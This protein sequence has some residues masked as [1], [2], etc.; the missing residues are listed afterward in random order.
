SLPLTPRQTPA[1][2][3]NWQRL[4]AARRQGTISG[5]VRSSE[6]GEPLSG[7]Q[8]VLDGT[9]R[10]TLSASNGSYSLADVPVGTYT[11]VARML[12][13]REVRQTDV[14]VVSGQ[15]INVNILLTPAA[16]SLEE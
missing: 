13:Y 10:G 5:T 4:P 15:A 6:T 16:L 3:S 11:I 8:V 1:F 7:V 14:Q 9:N 12:G 2:S